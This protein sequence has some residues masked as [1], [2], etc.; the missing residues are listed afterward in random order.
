[1]TSPSSSAISDRTRSY[2]TQQN[3]LP[4][5][6]EDS[7]VGRRSQRER[8]VSEL[9]SKSPA[10]PHFYSDR[11]T[12]FDRTAK[13]YSPY[14]GEKIDA[15]SSSW[16]TQQ[17]HALPSLSALNRATTSF[18]GK[19]RDLFRSAARPGTFETANGVRLTA[20]S[21]NGVDRRWNRRSN[22]SDYSFHDR[23]HGFGTMVPGGAEITDA[24]G[25]PYSWDINDSAENQMNRKR[26]GNLPKAATTMF[27][28]WFDEH[29]DS[30]YPTEEEKACFCRETGLTMNQVSL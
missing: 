18:P 24:A 27:K 15:M 14:R 13:N 7:N 21:S 17:A 20:T 9:F 8:S 26:R 23:S 30:P 3:Y 4:T 2:Q 19:D 25:P 11:A 22:S 10:R 1:M 16:N 12:T 29:R 5:A 6:C 28:K